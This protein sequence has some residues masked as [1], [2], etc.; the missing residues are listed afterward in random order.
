MPSVFPGITLK[1]CV[2]DIGLEALLKCQRLRKITM[3]KTINHSAMPTNR[4]ITLKGVRK[5]VKGLPNLEV[6]SFGSMG[7]IL[8]HNDFEEE[9]QVR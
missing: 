2:S 7:K 4:G 9:E 8:N 5:L 3:N 1:F 6:I